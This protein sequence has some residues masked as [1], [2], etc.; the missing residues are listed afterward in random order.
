MIL[1]CMR[2]LKIKKIIQNYKQY[3]FNVYYIIILLKIQ[4]L[5]NE[6]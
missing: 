3:L 4:D 6:K 5:I 2:H 1:R